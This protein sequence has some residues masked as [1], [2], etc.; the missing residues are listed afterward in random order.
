MKVEINQAI[1]E[2]D[3][4]KIAMKTK[5]L[6]LAYSAWSEA[7]FIQIVYTPNIFTEPEIKNLL[8]DSGI[9]NKWTML[10]NLSFEYKKIFDTKKYLNI[11]KSIKDTKE[12]NWKALLQETNNN[13]KQN[14]ILSK[15]RK[16]EIISY[17]KTYIDNQSKVRNK[18]AHGQW[19]NGL[20]SEDN[21]FGGKDLDTNLTT[22]IQNLN[23]VNIMIEFEVHTTLGKIIRELVQS[24]SKG[25]NNNYQKHITELNEFLNQSASWNMVDKRNIL[26]LRDKKI[27]CQE[28][29]TIIKKKR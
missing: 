25:F 10:I 9:F 7:Q 14:N 22:E 15:T 1:K 17:L 24:P 29:K 6:A 11:I 27:I 26:N 23:V 20:K 4:F 16:Q 13:Y 2:S 5:L 3:D 28:C 19:V 8:K 21:A 18:I 12:N